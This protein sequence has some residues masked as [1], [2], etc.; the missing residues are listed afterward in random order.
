MNIAK[1]TDY[2]D[3]VTVFQDKRKL[4][5]HIR[6]D[7]IDSM[8]RACKCVFQDGIVIM[9]TRYKRKNRIGNV[10]APK[11]TY[12]I[13]QIVNSSIGNGNAQKILTLFLTQV[14]DDV[15]LSVRADNARAIQFYIKNNF[16]KVGT[17][18][19]KNGTIPGHVYCY[20][21]SCLLYRNTTID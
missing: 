19:W 11:G 6:L 17:I 16:V 7:Y 1:T 8:I 21:K 18:A 12:T 9:F 20:P 10:I 5:P 3:I 13:K 15:Y 4:F 2:K 14:E